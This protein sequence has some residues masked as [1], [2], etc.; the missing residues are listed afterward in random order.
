MNAFQ[1]QRDCIFAQRRH[2]LCS[3]TNRIPNGEKSVRIWGRW[4]KRKK[5]AKTAS[6]GEGADR[7]CYFNHPT[8]YMQ[9]WIVAKRKCIAPTKNGEA[10]EGRT[11]GERHFGGTVMH[12]RQNSGDAAKMFHSYVLCTHQ[13]LK[14]LPICSQIWCLHSARYWQ[15]YNIFNFVHKLYRA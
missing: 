6:E 14:F 7:R 13:S 9:L 8:R 12:F 4:F 5:K 15:N 10:T 1:S 2:V 11:E 3:A